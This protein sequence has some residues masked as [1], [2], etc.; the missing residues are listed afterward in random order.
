MILFQKPEGGTYHL[1]HFFCIRCFEKTHDFFP[2][3]ALGR[4]WQR[5]SKPVIDLFEQSG[6]L[7]F[8]GV[9]LNELSAHTED[10]F[11]IH[12][13]FRQLLSLDPDILISGNIVKYVMLLLLLRQM[14][15][16]SVGQPHYVRRNVW[17]QANRPHDSVRDQMVLL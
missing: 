14:A 15:F 7:F 1:H 16:R 8:H 6:A 12:G 10:P 2:V 13:V 4:P 9:I 3:F 5:F 11:G 17:P